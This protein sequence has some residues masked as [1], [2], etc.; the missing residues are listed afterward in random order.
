M[1]GFNKEGLN[2][3][4]KVGF[5]RM[6]QPGAAATEQEALT[7]VANDPMAYQYSPACTALTWMAMMEWCRGVKCLA[8]STI[9]RFAD[10][11]TGH[12]FYARWN[13]VP[14][15]TSEEYT[16]CSKITGWK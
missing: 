16:R 1:R 4:R 3:T 15:V 8:D 5:W 13:G 6:G 7:V 9:F 14:E 12:A 10:P 2:M 11:E